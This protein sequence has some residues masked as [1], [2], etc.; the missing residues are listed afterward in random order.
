MPRVQRLAVAFLVASLVVSGAALAARGDPEKKITPA[1]QAR[2]RAMLLR[3]ADLGP[4]FKATPASAEGDDFYCEALDESDLTLTGD[5]ES[6]DFERELTFLSSLAQVYESVAD[7]SASWRRGTSAAGEKCVRDEF[8]KQ[9]Q[10]DGIRLIAFRRLAFPRLAQRTVAYRLAAASQGV[11]VYVDVVVLQQSRAQA[12]LLLG[13]ALTPL[14][15]AEEV[16]LA[17]GIADRMKTAMR[18]A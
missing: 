14:A 11:R 13:S 6:P 7:A 2:A 4:G 5:A 8:R 9:F 1:D 17:T 10:K 18:S 16:R 15:K 12:A 3:K